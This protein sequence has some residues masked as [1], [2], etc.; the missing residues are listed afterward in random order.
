MAAAL[1][2]A[3]AA[4]DDADDDDF[5]FDGA[6]EEGK[7][8]GF[9]GIET[10]VTV[11]VVVVVAVAGIV[12]VAVGAEVEDAG[13]DFLG[14]REYGEGSGSESGSAR[15]LPF[16]SLGGSLMVREVAGVEDARVVVFRDFLEG[17]LDCDSVDS[18][19]SS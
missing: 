6:V 5:P 3:R 19:W 8:P 2:L 14:R 7:R 18:G 15:F 1:A 10:V 12:A 17:L 9:L 4:D 16:E 11:V 13:A